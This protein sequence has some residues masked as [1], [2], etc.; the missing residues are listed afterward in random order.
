MANSL[1]N[2]PFAATKPLQ[3]LEEPRGVQPG[4]LGPHTQR[5]TV[6]P[7]DWA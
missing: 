3:A 5:W 7:K 6:P 2:Q 4:R 1:P